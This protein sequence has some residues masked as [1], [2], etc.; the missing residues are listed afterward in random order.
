[1]ELFNDYKRRHPDE[2]FVSQGRSQHS[3]HMS[4]FGR[5]NTLDDPNKGD[6]LERCL[7]EE[8]VPRHI[9]PLRW[10]EVNNERYPVLRHLAIDTLAATASSSGDEHVF[11]MAGLM[12][13]DEHFNTKSVL[14][15]QRRSS[16]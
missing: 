16:A 8:R 11:S 14:A 13:D 6:E 9:D 5:Y 15:L 2:A 4:E 3:E 12:L 10:W 7:G 1:M